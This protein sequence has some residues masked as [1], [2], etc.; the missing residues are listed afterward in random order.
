MPS[1]EL[2]LLKGNL[3]TTLRSILKEF[4]VGFDFYITSHTSE[5]RSIVH[6]SVGADSG[7]DGDRI[8]GIWLDTGNR[9][10]VISSVDN[11]REYRY[12]HN[13]PLSE[14]QWYNLEVEQVFIEDKV[15]HK[16]FSYLLIIGYL[17]LLPN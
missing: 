6:L 14:S 5:H 1:N 16:S 17:V 10:W 7:Q 3:L 8:P 11:N 9:L 4:H 13:L 15:E 2:Q 12:I